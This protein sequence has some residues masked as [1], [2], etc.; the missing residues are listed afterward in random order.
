[1]L[2]GPA[3]NKG[4]RQFLTRVYYNILEFETVLVKL[5]LFSRSPHLKSA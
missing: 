4:R 1:M 2:P 5:E 3:C